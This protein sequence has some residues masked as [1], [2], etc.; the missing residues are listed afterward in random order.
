MKSN[1]VMTATPTENEL[2][3]EAHDGNA[4]GLANALHNFTLLRRNQYPG[5]RRIEWCSCATPGDEVYWRNPGTGA[6]GWMC[7]ECRGITQTG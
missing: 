6:H 5:M 7:G 4:V 1:E 3:S 2:C